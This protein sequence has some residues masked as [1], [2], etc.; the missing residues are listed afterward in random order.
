[1]CSLVCHCLHHLCSLPG[2]LKALPSLRLEDFW[3]KEKAVR[4]R[5]PT[6]GGCSG[7]IHR[8]AQKETYSIL[9]K[10]IAKKIH[11]VFRVFFFP[12]EG[13]IEWEGVRRGVRKDLSEE[14]KINRV[15]KDGKKK[16]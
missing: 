9:G 6:W 11:F 5:G 3:S 10:S 8:F 13:V 1:M 4:A 15:P 7:L 14:R 16:K 2:P 12:L